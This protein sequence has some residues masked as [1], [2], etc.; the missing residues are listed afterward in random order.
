MNAATATTYQCD[1]VG[2]FEFG[3]LE[4]L[5]A[6]AVPLTVQLTCAAPRPAFSP[7]PAGTLLPVPVP[8]PLLLLPPLLPL[9]PL[10]LPPLVPPAPL[11]LLPVV[12]PA[13]LL[14]LAVSPFIGVVLHAARPSAMTPPRI[15]LDIV[16][17][18]IA[19]YVVRVCRCW[20]EF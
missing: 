13:P 6:S 3:V 9:P 17:F 4:A 10:P 11:L 15:K 18:I 16:V 7:V 1:S 12:A 2:H 14:P 5:E 19:P 20:R 8:L